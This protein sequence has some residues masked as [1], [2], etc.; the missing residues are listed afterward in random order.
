MDR[1]R[2]ALR[3]MA[4]EDPELAARLIIQTLPAA[5]SRIRAPLRYQLTVG[6]MGT[7]LVVVDDEGARVAVDTF[8][9]LV[10]GEIS[11]A[12]SMR[13]QLADIDGEIYPTVLVGR[14]IERAQGRDDDELEREGRQRDI[15]SRRAGSWGGSGNGA[16]PT[17]V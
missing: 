12:Q 5:A 11:P 13:E 15:Q 7:W 8:K 3:E 10:S 9:R 14:W 1:T 6:D 4:R 17:E 16:R 2:T